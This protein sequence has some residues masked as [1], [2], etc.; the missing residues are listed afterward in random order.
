MK[1]RPSIIGNLKLSGQPAPE[2]T[3]A[4]APP[5]APAI[6]S[7]PATRKDR[8]D[9]VHTS[10]YI[11]KPVHRKLREIAFVEERKVH[12]LVMEGI[13]AVLKKYGHPSVAELKGGNS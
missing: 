3:K 9:T 4:P 10:L 8:P 1:K 7:E 6:A 13:D 2:E 5:A 12:D 11:P